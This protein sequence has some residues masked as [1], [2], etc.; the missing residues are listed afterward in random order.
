MMFV[1]QAIVDDVRKNG[2]Y[3][4]RWMTVCN[5]INRI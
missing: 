3:T 4:D 2:D 1:S 5:A